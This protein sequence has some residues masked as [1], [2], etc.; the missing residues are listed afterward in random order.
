MQDTRQIPL[1][2]HI[3]FVGKR[4]DSTLNARPF[5]L[6]HKEDAIDRLILL[7]NQQSHPSLPW[8]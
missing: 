7:H 6:R 2:D 5:L 3:R 8:G 1:D 4:T